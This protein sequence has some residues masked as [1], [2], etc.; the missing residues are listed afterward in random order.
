MTPPR[1]P[2]VALVA[3]LL[4]AG[5]GGGS[6]TGNAPT[7]A[8]APTP[9]EAEAPAP[10]TPGTGPA[11]TYKA[12]RNVAYRLERHDSL[13]LQYP[14]GA[15]QEQ[16]RDR[17]AYLRVTVTE[18]PTAGAYQVAIVLDSLQA[19][20]G[21]QPVSPDSVAA[22]RGTRWTA[23]LT[24]GG[25]L[26][27]LTPDRTGT[28]PDELTGRLRLL[29][30]ALPAGG[31]REGMEWTDTTEYRLTADAFPGS[32]RAVTTYRATESDAPGMR[33]GITLE[34]DGSYDR[35]GTRSQGDQELQ[36]QASGKRRGA[37]VLGLDGSLVS[38]RGNDSG[39]MTITVPTVGQTVPV[40]QSGSFAI[41]SSPSR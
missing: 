41:T 25:G 34:S 6:T 28:L 3:V 40:K 33:K 36:M 38:A 1:A 18:S 30:P 19:L 20:E 26:G 8:P 5:C 27:A 31:V 2:S 37:H 23:T 24:T 4:V 11:V 39:D 35:T 9:G 14:G 10:T 15:T 32:E 21:G 17:I 29:F 13:S 12:V 16:V 7:P 22:A